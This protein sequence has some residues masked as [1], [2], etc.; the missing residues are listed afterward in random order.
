MSR[1]R[2]QSIV[3]DAKGTDGGGDSESL[4]R[5][6]VYCRLRPTKAVDGIG[7]DGVYKLVELSKKQIK[8]DGEKIYNFDGS[9]NPDCTQEDIF[10]EVAKPSIEHVLKGFTAA[11]M[12]YGQTGTGK[13]FTMSHTTPGEE[14]IIPRSAGYLFEMIEQN[15]TKNYELTAHFV[16]I[17]RDNLSDLMSEKGDKVDVRFDVKKGVEILNCTKVSVATKQDFLDMYAEGDARRVVRPTNMN[18]ESSRGHTALVLYV[19]CSPNDPNDISKPTEGKITF[20]DLAGYER[21][22]KTG[23]KDPIHKDEAKKINASLLSL[24]HVVTALSNGEKHIPWRNAKL[25]RLLQDSIGGKS[26]STIIIT[27]GPSSSSLHETTNSLDFGNRAMAVKVSA[28]VDQDIDYQK[29]AAKLEALLNEKEERLN[30]LELAEKTREVERIERERRFKNDLA[31]LRTRHKEELTQ[32]MNEGATSER[33][34]ALL[35]QHEVEDQN[36]QEEQTMEREIVEEGFQEEERE[37]VDEIEQQHRVRAQSMRKEGLEAKQRELDAAYALIAQLRGDGNVTDIAAEISQMAGTPAGGEDLASPKT[38]TSAELGILQ[39]EL[40]KV[41]RD[42]AAEEEKLKATVEKVKTA[43]LKCVNM[44]KEQKEKNKKLM[45]EAV[46]A[47][48]LERLQGENTALKTAHEQSIALREEIEEKLHNA[49]A[50]LNS[51]KS[52]CQRL[53]NESN[54]AA[55]VLEELKG[56][57]ASLETRLATLE[58]EKIELED[59]F[60]R[61]DREREAV[62][63][64]EGT[65]AASKLKELEDK[66]AQL[67]QQIASLESALAELQAAKDELEDERKT[68][69]EALEEAEKNRKELEAFREKVIDQ[70]EEL[71]GEHEEKEVQLKDTIEQLEDELQ[72]GTQYQEALEK[73][74][75]ELEQQLGALQ[76]DLKTEKTKA[77][78]EAEELRKKTQEERKTRE[79]ETKRLLEQ[80][81]REKESL[82]ERMAKELEEEKKKGGAKS[83]KYSSKVVSQLVNVGQ[84][85]TPPNAPQILRPQELLSS[86]DTDEVKMAA[87]YKIICVGARGTGKSSV[88]KCLSHEGSVGLFKKA[89]DVVS[90]TTSMSMV[91]YTVV[92]KTGNKGFLAKKSTL[93]TYFQ[94]WD[95]PCSIKGIRALPAGCLPLSGCAY[96]LTYALNNEFYLEAKKMEEVLYAVYANCKDRMQ[97]DKVKIPVVAMGT[98][99]DLV[100]KDAGMTKKAEEVKKWFREHPLAK[101]KFWLIDAYAVSCKEWSVHSDSG[102]KHG[103][104]SFSQVMHMFANE[105]HKRYP[106]NPQSLLGENIT[107]GGSAGMEL[108]EW[109]HHNQD[110]RDEKERVRKGAYKGVLSLLVHIGRL[111]MRG[112]WLMGAYEFTSLCMEHIPGYVLDEMPGVID[113]VK[114]AFEDRSLVLP[115]RDPAHDD[116]R[117]GVFVLG[118][119]VVTDF[120]ASLMLPTQ[121]LSLLGSFPNEKPGYLKNVLQKHAKF[122]VEEVWRPDWELLFDGNISSTAV[123]SLLKNSLSF[124]KDPSLGRSFLSCMGLCFKVRV[125]DEDMD[126]MPAMALRNF[127]PELESAVLAAYAK[128]TDGKTPFTMKTEAV[129]PWDIVAILKS[130]HSTADICYMWSNAAMV[131]HCGEWGYVKFDLRSVTVSCGGKDAANVSTFIKSHV[132][133]VLPGAEWKDGQILDGLPRL[134]PSTAGLVDDAA[135]LTTFFKTLPVDTMRGVRYPT[136]ILEDETRKEGRKKFAKGSPQKGKLDSSRLA[137]FEET[138]SSVRSGDT[139]DDTLN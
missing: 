41:K 91:D 29:L 39:R 110:V 81:T 136:N 94:I 77:Q 132:E 126:F 73:R 54:N 11:I 137:M 65:A 18:P 43:H 138:T 127:S 78:L 16:Q 117:E 124:N 44:L 115:L 59:E 21:F 57:K 82:K 26:R 123:M 32:L 107:Y 113:S 53:Q 45:E 34:Q 108:T 47:E 37:I 56:E 51:S 122:N 105:L 135:D 92:D 121:Y 33:I 85:P 125:K 89:P 13:S 102:G 119:S 128:H 6:L 114:K 46:N 42:A 67:Q 30:K 63:E 116:P 131:Q 28:K 22:D 19:K 109:W 23:V 14:G 101:D 1:A 68:A 120:I 84:L 69:I 98:M 96:V 3:E 58:A 106:V 40:E 66:I 76:G 31:R 104:S 7:Q 118:I 72:S 50:N 79:E 83:F 100:G 8:V 88:Q 103:V 2:A 130:L 75:E 95:T 87:R 90:P 80:Q 112:I 97:D 49:V 17:Y 61:K 4:Q 129:T 24:G 139:G 35:K 10:Q 36:L 133:A 62:K 99:R 60:N 27:I 5:C 9:F 71:K 70:F 20:I 15:T 48:E 12:A 55:K 134:L 93:H 86:L 52:D 38:A 74:V 111:K 25:T 64:E